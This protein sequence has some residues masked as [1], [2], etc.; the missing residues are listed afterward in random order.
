MEVCVMV[1]VYEQYPLV[2]RT[3]RLPWRSIRALTLHV[4][5][6]RGRVLGE[7][8]LDGVEAVELAEY[9]QH[10]PCGVFGGA[11]ARQPHLRVGP[12]PHLQAAV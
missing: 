4:A 11:D 7:L 10:S 1:T 9:E 8:P 5:V 2:A 3:H 6:E 12:Q